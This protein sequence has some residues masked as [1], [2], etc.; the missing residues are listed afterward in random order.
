VLSLA[1]YRYADSMG[2]EYRASLRNID[3][4]QAKAHAVSGVHYAAG[5]LADPSSLYGELGGNPYDT[6]T[7]AGVHIGPSNGPRG[8]GRFSLINLSDRGGS[9][10]DRY[11]LRY[12]VS[13]EAGKINVNALIASDTTGTQLYNALLALPDMTPTIADCIVDWVDGNSSPRSMGAEES[14]YAGLA[15]PYHCKN[16][17]INSLEE[18]LLVKGVTPQLL[19]GSDRNR[20]GVQDPGEDDG[21]A[22]SRGWSE[23]LTCYGRD[24]NV[25]ST[26]MPRFNINDTNL[27]TLSTNLTSLVGQPLSDYIIYFRLTGTSQTA[28]TAGTTAVI[29]G[30]D[31]LRALVD[32]AI[33][34]GSQPKRKISSMLTVFGTE[35]QL[36]ATAA[37]PMPGPPGRAPPPTIVPCPLND[38]NVLKQVLPLLMDK[39]STVADYELAPRVNVNTAPREVLLGLAS[40]N[41]KAIVNS[42]TASS[43]T[44]G[45]ST[46]TSTSTATPTGLTE[47]DVDSIIAARD[48]Q[49]ASDTATLTGA[50][51][52]T[53]ANIDPVKFKTIEPFITGRT[54]T[55]R[56]HSVGY[57]ANGGPVSRV[58]AVIDTTLGKP[59][60]LYF[61][62]LTDLGRGFTNLPK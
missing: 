15:Q 44:T 21:G 59:R 34:A 9:G 6:S 36:P 30:P 45:S 29:A 10:A 47:A 19:F 42:S 16:G 57:F 43:S 17:P 51:M 8:G 18:L 2:T 11:P 20:N 49:S 27:Q 58:E 1:A 54:Y 53:A 41:G 48:G 4:V 60:I 3:A 31:Q 23:Y 7:F 5:M 12:G 26:G 56:V 28:G 22:F 50:W 39:S 61:R 55:Y 25:D 37:A 40:I 33:Q 46:T 13:D 52:V 62:E 14:D 35:I 32:K 24:V 38:V